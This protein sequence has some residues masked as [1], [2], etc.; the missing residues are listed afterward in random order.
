MPRRFALSYAQAIRRIPRRR[1]WPVSGLIVLISAGLVVYGQAAFSVPREGVAQLSLGVPAYV[2][3]GQAPLQT[4][5]SMSPAPG[6]VILNPD[7]GDGPFGPAWQAQA[8][9]LRARSITVLGYVYTSDATRPVADAETAIRNYLGSRPGRAHIS[10]IFLDEMSTSCS[11]YS[12]YATLYRYIHQ[13]DPAAFVAAN[14]GTPVNVCFLSPRNTVANTFVTFEHDAS[15]YESGYQG[16]VI[17]SNGTVSA[18]SQYPARTFWHLIYGAGAGQMPR[19]VALAEQR[20]AGYAYVTDASLPNPWASVPSY[21]TAEAQA[22]AQ[23]PL[24]RMR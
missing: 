21:L 24:H 13:L 23:A 20:H 19:L 18:G 12:Y 4:L 8:D 11:A 16:N 1:L 9:R 14:P 15:S 22:M 17:G 10:G 6:I 2:F 5:Q 3:P 7:N